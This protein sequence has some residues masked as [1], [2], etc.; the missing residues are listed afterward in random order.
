E[1]GVGASATAWLAERSAALAAEGESVLAVASADGELLGAIAVADRIRPGAREALAALREEGVERLVM[2]TGDR[3]EVAERIA[4]ELGIDEVRAELLP[5]DKSAV[6]A[7]LRERHGAVAMVGDGIN[8]A[9]ALATADVGIAM[10]V[11]G[12]DVALESADLALMKD[13]LSTL[14]RLFDLSRRT[15]AIIR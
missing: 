6:I 11:A 3:R 5:D 4:V 8:D 13:D 7:E 1:T 14:A 15:L 9:P 2:L 12:S 10:G